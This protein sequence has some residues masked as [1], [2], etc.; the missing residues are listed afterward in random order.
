MRG[1]NFTSLYR[2][3]AQFASSLIFSYISVFGLSFIL[4][5]G[6]HCEKKKKNR[7]FFLIKI[8]NIS[9]VFADKRLSMA[10]HDN[11]AKLDLYTSK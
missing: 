3:P 10:D 11:I 2:I 8:L 6:K 1:Y 7:N 9:Y 4:K 5:Y